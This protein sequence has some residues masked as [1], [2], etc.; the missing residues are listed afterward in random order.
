[1]LTLPRVAGLLLSISTLLAAGCSAADPDEGDPSNGSP[2]GSPGG[3]GGNGGGGNGG[4]G[5]GGGNVPPPEP[6]KLGCEQ[7]EYSEPLPT[8]DSLSGLTFSSGQAANYLLSALEIR[9]P[10]GRDI[11]DD[12]RKIGNKMGD[13]VQMF[14][15]PSPDRARVLMQGSTIVHE[16]G[17]FLD[18]AQGGAGTSVYV[19]RPGELT[20]ECKEGD[21]TTRY[22]RTFARSLIRN[23]AYASLRPP[24]KGGGAKGCDFYANTYLDGDPNDGT[25]QGGDQGYNSVLE[26][27][28]QYVNS[29]ATALAFQE[30]YAGSMA[31]ERDGILT[32][33]WYLERYLAM[34]R[35]DYPDAYEFLTGDSCWRQAT[36]TVWDR[37]WFYLRAT[38]DLGTLGI[39]DDAIEQLV[40]DPD[41]LGEIDA[42][43]QLE[44]Q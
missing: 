41:L 43:R 35:T 20:F 7:E 39:D 5:A 13:C 17:H 24:C 25:F 9:Y 2:I 6:G 26:E 11:V 4:G 16:C 36:L 29:L 22:G 42:L 23:D 27:T 3:G 12:A 15:S 44:C 32:F 40:N 28:T 14:L 31:S 38:E 33:L 37:A 18:M 8:K 30:V 1:M 34:A 10:V 19:I 21:T